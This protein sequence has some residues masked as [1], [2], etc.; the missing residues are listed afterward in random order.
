MQDAVAVIKV[1]TNRVVGVI[2]TEHEGTAATAGTEGRVPS[3][4][5]A[6]RPA[7]SNLLTAE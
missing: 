6:S 1:P 4:K 3:A 5:V 2:D 7:A